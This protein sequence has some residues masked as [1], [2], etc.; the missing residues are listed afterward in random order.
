MTPTDA[1]NNC[2]LV[3]QVG[4]VVTTHFPPVAHVS[5]NSSLTF[6]AS[7]H[8]AITASSPHLVGSQHLTCHISVS[9]LVA[10]RVFLSASASVMV[11][12]GGNGTS[13][14]QV[15]GTLVGTP[16]TGKG[17][18]SKLFIAVFTVWCACFVI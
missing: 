4:A 14:V 8:N 12:G 15:Q 7:T 16:S 13:S 10:G 2:S 6:S 18:A 9:P 17:G 11:V 3:F 5:M 1:S